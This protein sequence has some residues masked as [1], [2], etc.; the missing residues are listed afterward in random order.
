MI[1]IGIL[2][3]PLTVN[4]CAS[5]D[6]VL[7]E[8]VSVMASEKTFTDHLV[9]WVSGKDCSIVR[10]EQEL[11]YCLEDEPPILKPRVY[12]YRTLGSVSCYDRPD[13]RR[14]SYQLMGQDDHNLGY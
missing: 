1:L 2:V 8:G 5:G 13:P 3:S 12:C 14:S 9:S 10:T 11:E 4:G 7:I 6:F